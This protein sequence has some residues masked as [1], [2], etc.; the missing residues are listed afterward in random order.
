MKNKFLAELFSWL[1]ALAVAL[2]I[3]LICRQFLITP[4]IVKGESMMPNLED[5]DRIIL[6]K[7]SEINRFDEI[8]FKAPDTNDNYVKRVIGVPGDRVEMRND[9]LYI[10]GETY[11]E[12]YLQE[13]KSHI[14]EGQVLTRDFELDDVTQHEVV[15]E[16]KYFVLGDNRRVSKDSRKFGYIDQEAIIGDVKFRIWPL[17]TFG[18]ID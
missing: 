14:P 9:Q 1:K 13:L 8:A 10:N 5:G 18:M 7:I 16:G 11:E 3:V 12:P 15:P 17:D 2:I 4:S 6:S